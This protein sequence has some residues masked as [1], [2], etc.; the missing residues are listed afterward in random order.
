M[1]FLNEI[2]KITTNLTT[3]KDEAEIVLK[4]N[5]THFKDQEQTI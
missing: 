5:S 3:L 2:Q 1:T 4:S